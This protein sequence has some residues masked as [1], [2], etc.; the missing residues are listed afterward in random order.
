MLVAMESVIEQKG[1]NSGMSTSDSA[2]SELD[3]AYAEVKRE[4]EV[5]LGGANMIDRPK[6]IEIERWGSE[7]WA[8]TKRDA[9]MCKY[10][11]D[12]SCISGSGVSVCGGYCGHILA[13]DAIWCVCR[14]GA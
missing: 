11:G 6:L 12:S 2:A 13:N 4:S 1:R 9:K 7:G 8:P 5:M 10:N 3:V 14:E